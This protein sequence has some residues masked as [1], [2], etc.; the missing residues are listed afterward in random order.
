MGEFSNAAKTVEVHGQ[1]GLTFRNFPVEVK[2]FD[3]FLMCITASFKVVR[4]FTFGLIPT[5]T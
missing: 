2:I 1:R 4:N 5:L 3:I